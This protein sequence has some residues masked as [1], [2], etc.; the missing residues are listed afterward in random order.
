VWPLNF[1]RLVN[2]FNFIFCQSWIWMG[3]LLAVLSVESSAF[4]CTNLKCILKPDT[5]VWDE[6]AY[7]VVT[8]RGDEESEHKLEPAEWPAEGVRHLRG[9][10]PNYSFASIW[11]KWS[12]SQRNREPTFSRLPVYQDLL[13]PNSPLSS[14]RNRLAKCDETLNS[15]HRFRPKIEEI[16]KRGWNIAIL[17]MTIR[18]SFRL[19]LL[20]RY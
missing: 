8:G 13:M 18:M 16:V 15:Y 17:S 6:I 10:G 11:K 20:Y 14:A 2:I 4:S 3:V 7:V 5:N 1:R 9:S 12:F 19:G